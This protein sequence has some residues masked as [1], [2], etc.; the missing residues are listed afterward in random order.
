[1]RDRK[2]KITVGYLDKNLCLSHVKAQVGNTELL[3]CFITSETQMASIWISCVYDLDLMVQSRG[4][5]FR[6]KTVVWSTYNISGRAM[7]F[8]LSH[9]P[10]VCHKIN[11]MDNF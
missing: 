8:E 10:L 7:L 1:M 9:D 11:I 6:I 4:I 2:F 3:W 5:C